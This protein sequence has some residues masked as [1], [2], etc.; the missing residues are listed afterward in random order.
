MHCLSLVLTGDE[1]HG[2]EALVA[3]Y[4]ASEIGISPTSV[5]RD[6]DFRA[7]SGD[8]LVALRVCKRLAAHVAGGS[9]GDGGEDPGT[10]GEGLVTLSPVFLF[11]N[12]MVSAFAHYLATRVGDPVSAEGASDS[13]VTPVKASVKGSVKSSVNATLALPSG[14]DPANAM[15]MRNDAGARMPES[16]ALLVEAAAAGVPSLVTALL[17]AVCVVLSSCLSLSN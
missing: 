7:L 6:S 3:R 8:S 10:F 16:A 1:L 2:W 14:E 5:T 15:L 13:L 9:G 17:P 4:L 12:P 11:D